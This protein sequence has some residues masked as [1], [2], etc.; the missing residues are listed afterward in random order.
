[1]ADALGLDR[2]GRAQRMVAADPP[3]GNVAP[4]A[5]KFPQWDDQS[6]LCE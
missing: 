4:A 2:A 6:A 1:M 3:R 5:A